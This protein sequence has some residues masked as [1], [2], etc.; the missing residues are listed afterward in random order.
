MSDR[1]LPIG[2]K[3]STRGPGRCATMH[4][5]PQGPTQNNTNENDQTDDSDSDSDDPALQPYQRP[6]MPRFKGPTKEQKTARQFSPLS[7]VPL[8]ADEQWQNW[9]A[10]QFKLEREHNERR[11]VLLRERNL[12]KRGLAQHLAEEDV[13]MEDDVEERY[14]YSPSRRGA[15]G[16]G[17]RH[18]FVRNE[19]V[20]EEEEEIEIEDEVNSRRE[21]PPPLRQATSKEAGRRKHIRV[22][23]VD[24]DVLSPQA[25]DS[26]RRKLYDEGSESSYAPDHLQS[27]R[28]APN[29]PRRP[30]GQ[31]SEWRPPQNRF[32][33]TAPSNEPG[34]FSSWPQQPH[35]SHPGPPSPAPGY[36]PSHPGTMHPQPPQPH[37]DIPTSFSP[38]SPRPHSQPQDPPAPQVRQ[39]PEVSSPSGGLFVTPPPRIPAPQDQEGSPIPAVKEE[40]TDEDLNDGSGLNSPLRSSSVQQSHPTTGN[41]EETETA[42]G[43]EEDLGDLPCLLFKETVFTTIELL[44][45]A[46]IG[47]LD[48]VSKAESKKTVPMSDVVRK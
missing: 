22:E 17:R 7:K 42:E 34:S 28:R 43:Q 18:Q 44:L 47:Q 35:S 36:Q 3:S 32:R 4:P 41:G 11:E 19:Q 30:N 20:D 46:P 37:S 21:A 6:K 5:P 12:R 15:S 33:Y 13:E 29:P 24:E 10:E 45:G 8:S 39:T 16:R 48:V 23:Q 40:E 27:S 2:P 26:K 31:A 38:P 9:E 25:S 1:R 14:G